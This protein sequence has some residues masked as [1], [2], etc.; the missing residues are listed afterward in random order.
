[1]DLM[2]GMYESILLSISLKKSNQIYSTILQRL[3]VGVHHWNRH[4]S[5]HNV[6]P[7][8]ETAESHYGWIPFL[9]FL[10]FLWYD[11]KAQVVD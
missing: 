4:H 3:Q 8:N 7:Y 10:M 2:K 11:Q 5:F 1:M 6:L 9:F